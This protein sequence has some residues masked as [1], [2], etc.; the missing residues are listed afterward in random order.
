MRLSTFAALYS[1][2]FTAL[3][4][5]TAPAQAQ[6]TQEPT[7]EAE[8][9]PAADA[10]DPVCGHIPAG[11]ERDR[12]LAGEVELESGQ[13][14]R[15]GEIVVTGSRIE[16]PNI[17]STVPI[18]SVGAQELLDTGD[19]SL[20]DQL[21]QLPS[22]RSTFSQ[23][24]STRFIGTAGLNL[25]D[26]RGLGT[27][28][29]LVLVNGRRHVTSTP[30]S[31]SVDVNTIPT[32]LLERVDVITGG[33]SAIYGSDAVSGVVNFVLR[34][35]FEGIR[36]RGQGGVSDEGDRGSYF[37]SGIAGKNFWE[38]RANVAIAV[39]YAKTKKVLN[40]DRP[41][42]TGAFVGAPAFIRVDT[43][44]PGTPVDDGVF[45]FAFFRN[46]GLSFGQISGGGAVQ[47]SCLAPLA[48]TSPGFAAREELRAAVCTGDLSPTGARLSDNYFF[49]PG[50]ILA[51]NDPA[52]DLRP[53]GGSILGGLG[54]SAA[55]PSGMLLPGLERLAANLLFNVEL[56]PIFQPFAE[57]KFVRVKAQ[58]QS[59]Q[60][61]FIAGTLNPIFRRDNPFLTPEAR[62][63]LNTI[64][65]PGSTF[66]FL[67]FNEDIGTRAEDHERDTYRI[68]SGVRG[69]ISNTGNLKYEVAF[70]YGRTETYYET[71]GNV[72]VARFN[73]A[74]NAVRDPATGQIV[75]AV[76][77]DTNPA[78]DMPGCVP[79][80]LFGY[81]APSPE[82]AN[83]VLHTSSRDQWAKQINAVGFL[84][85][86]T[87]GFFNLPGGPIG[88][89]VGAEYRKEDAY[90]DY[91]DVTQA[92]ETFL[93]AF[94][95]F[96]PPPITVKE[97]FGELRVPILADMPFFNELT[98]EGAAR[99]SDYSTSG[100]VWAYN[101]GAI[102][103][104]VRDLRI[105]G[106]Y[107]RAVRAPD[108]G[109]L[110]A[111]RTET[112]A[113]GLVDP[114]NQTVIGENP[115]RAA[116]CAEAGIPTTITLP[117]GSV[118]PWTNAPASGVSGF[119]QGNPNLRP[120]VGKS[121][122]VGAVIQ[123]RF[124][125]GLSLTVDWYNI[126]IEK[127][128]SGLSGQAII[129]RCY[130][131]PVSINNPFCQAVFRRRT[132]GDPITD[133]T[134]EGQSN[135]VFPGFPTFTFDRI[136]PGFLNQPFNF[137]QL[138]TSGIDFD[139]AYRRTVLNDVRLDLRGIVSWVKNR[140]EFTFV[141]DPE[142]STRLHGTLGDPEWAAS[143]SANAD[144]GVIDFGYDLR[145][146]DQMTVFSWETQ[147]SH[148]GREP[149]N[150]DALK[151]P[152][153]P[154]VFYHDLRV[155]FEPTERFRFYV[156]V[157]NVLDRLPPLDL[158]G[159]GGGS[160]IYPVTGRFFYA[161]ARTTF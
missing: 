145:W 69:D 19:V 116:R 98:V 119:N 29:T 46:P 117:D 13:D 101:A 3:V 161:G 76:N 152:Y 55:V 75:C 32:E 135:R 17:A 54:T 42:Q 112:F 87:E 38:D 4:V 28:R 131:D 109:D 113:N 27:D 91:D 146:I 47:T 80:N 62:Q 143:F 121:W 15:E 36:I 18:T 84:S 89:A 129:N 71:G 86:N 134:F 111:T 1:V 45:D 136:G 52:M 92:G 41:D 114:C 100:G 128:I 139:L 104:P 126:T 107:A 26:L 127:A 22:L 60:P 120:E 159:T 157:D 103:S 56:S 61:T 50:G 74:S 6:V 158:T 141:N 118:V 125:P 16:R 105:R 77:I 133:F 138:K 81:G 43:D 30:G 25:L 85:G 39:E 78:N 44:L 8:A 142:R 153:Y 147:F 108:L 82:A 93:N 57:A 40:R 11:P 10:P 65:S 14:Q 63:T 21:N 33:N 97:A 154:D 79:I 99:Y 132:P 73:A 9:P 94:D 68:V 95:T 102:W 115:N 53:V 88:F 150:P 49:L 20:G 31:F 48:P 2:S 66:V 137:Q 72:H 90:S 64:L 149:T 130:E 67:R 144:F 155:G 110:F 151:D 58:Q 24:N 140:E 35:D 122:T 124:V 70:N 83:Y 12:C 96:A 51:R 148:Q 160:G 7:S 34:R 156:G 5:A 59:S 106:G 37:I 123:P 23:A